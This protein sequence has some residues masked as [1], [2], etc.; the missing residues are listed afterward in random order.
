MSRSSQSSGTNNALHLLPPAQMQALQQAYAEPARG[1]HNW[2]HVVE[3]LRHY[4]DVEAGS[5]WHKPREVLIAILYHDAVY[6]PG[7]KDNEA[8]SAQLAVAHLRQWP[9]KTDIDA[10][11]VCELIVATA[12]HGEHSPQSIGEGPDA[13]DMRHFLDC[14]MAI[15]GAYTDAFD[16]YERG[17]AQEYRG[18][19]PGFIF[20]AKRRSF[21][22]KLLK[23]PRIY[24]SDEFHSRFDAK[25][26]ANLR[27]TLDD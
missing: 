6:V 1:Y 19:V 4:D 7:R 17:I 23:K 25:A 16:N 14:D 2:N 8:R 24:L 5:G 12:H 15:L 13:D 3:V 10:Q 18:V 21:L 20:R 9:G 11:R 26:R 22:R 27:R